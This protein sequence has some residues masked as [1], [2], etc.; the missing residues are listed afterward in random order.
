M[1][2]TPFFYLLFLFLSK[3]YRGNHSI[4]IK[5]FPELIFSA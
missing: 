4:E 1:M 3:S 2:I 5:I